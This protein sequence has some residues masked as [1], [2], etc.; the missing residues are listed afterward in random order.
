MLTDGCFLTKGRTALNA[1]GGLRMWC[2]I[3]QGRTSTP[4]V[5][6]LE[7]RRRQGASKL[8]SCS[9]DPELEMRASYKLASPQCVGSTAE[10][11]KP[12]AQLR[13][14]PAAS[15]GGER[16]QWESGVVSSDCRYGAFHSFEYSMINASSELRAR[17]WARLRADAFMVGL[18]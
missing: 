7:L 10:R 5:W 4:K 17:T 6:Q 18:S 11:S 15:L 1:V 9:Y 14:L 3:Q 12:Y 13:S 8:S 16:S 2:C